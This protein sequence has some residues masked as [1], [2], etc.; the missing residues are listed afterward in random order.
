MKDLYFIHK[1]LTCVHIEPHVGSIRTLSDKHKANVSSV[2]TVFGGGAFCHLGLLISE[3][4]YDT[5]SQTPFMCPVNRCP[6][7]TSEVGISAQMTSA[8][9]VWRDSA[10]TYEQCQA[11]EKDLVSQVLAE[12]YSVYFAALPNSTT[13]CCGDNS[14]HILQH[15][16][17]VYGRS[18]PRFLK[19]KEMR[20]TT[21]FRTC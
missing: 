2:S 20:F 10:W 8:H 7:V 18:T 14:Q 4:Q 13:S 21:W 12:V 1:R 6:F 15:L 17:S 9:G 11:V 19:S 3:E 5:H 16:M